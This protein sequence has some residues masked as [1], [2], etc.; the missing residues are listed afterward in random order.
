MPWRNGT[1]GDALADVT[2]GYDP[3][4]RRLWRGDLTPDSDAAFD[5]Y[6]LAFSQFEKALQIFRGIGETQ[7]MVVCLEQM[8]GI[9]VLINNAGFGGT[10]APV[11]EQTDE[12]ILATLATNL[13][14]VILGCARAAR[15]MCAQRSGAIINISS[16]CALSTPPPASAAP[17]RIR[18]R[19]GSASVR[20]TS[21]NWSSRCC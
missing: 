2:Y 3:A 17:P 11:S 9:D 12:A 1:S 4:S 6:D 8:G 13:T 21:A 7:G 20:T 19:P 10:L 14:G 16:V 18:R 5:R 15:I